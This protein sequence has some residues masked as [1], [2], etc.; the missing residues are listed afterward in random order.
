MIQR[1]I[2]LTRKLGAFVSERLEIS[3]SFQ[4]ADTILRSSSRFLGKTFDGSEIDGIGKRV[5]NESAVVGGYVIPWKTI[6]A[7]HD[8]PG[9]LRTRSEIKI[10]LALA[11]T[12]ARSGIARAKATRPSNAP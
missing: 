9:W 4:H 3:H 8:W 12:G 6:A 1:F 5:V 11:L 10:D 7:E 2:I